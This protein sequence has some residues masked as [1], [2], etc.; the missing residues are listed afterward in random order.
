MIS[1][2]ALPCPKCQR[3]LDPLSWHDAGSGACRSCRTA[4][5]FVGFPALTAPL[6]RAV[7][8]AVLVSEH[9]TCFFHGD[10]E[11]ESVCESCGRFLCAVCAIEFTGRQLCPSCIA[12][13]KTTDAKAVGDRL[14]YPGIALAL[15]VLPL[16]L[17]PVTFVTAPLALGF[18]I[19]GW[20]KPPS[21]VRTGRV[22]LVLAGLIA[23]AQIVGWLLVIFNVWLT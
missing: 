15:A 11:A 19:V 2:P 8:K 3:V 9:S 23:V 13:T 16:L 22:K 10:N 5:E 20:R 7:P 21:L 18:V 14:I 1:G 4:F 17:W 12:T 6:R